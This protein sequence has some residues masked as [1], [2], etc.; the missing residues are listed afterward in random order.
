MYTKF[1]NI[2]I[3]GC[4]GF[5]GSHLTQKFL[6]EGHVV[7]GVDDLSTGKLENMKKFIE[8][9][10]F[11][12]LEKDVRE[13]FFIEVDLILNFAC[14]A[15]PKAYQVDPVRTIETNFLGIINLLQLAKFTG[16]KLVQASTSEVYG[17][18]KETPQKESYWGNVNPVG[19]RSCYDEGKRAAETLCFDY[20]RQYG[21]DARV[22]RI[23]NTY[24]PNMAI[25]DGRVVSN[26]INQAI[27]NEPIT[28]YGDGSQTRSFCF[29]TDLI[30]GLFNVS[31]L[32]KALETPIN[33][34]NPEEFSMLD[35]AN[36]IK[37]LTKSESEIIFKELP[38][39]DPLQR[40]PDVS[41]AIELI[42][43][44][45]LV[46]I[47]TGLNKTINYFQSIK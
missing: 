40:R 38:S 16:A 23:F 2:L 34:G 39:D 28:I 45:P 42:N 30:T 27:R 17:D 12:F 21:V 1:M 8:D 7:T 9:K 22:V 44:K 5:L 15:S 36:K 37:L 35:L 31:I 11:N 14:P 24:G 29:V 33:L 20:K 10:N 13:K 18:P 4:A 26:F 41:L 46:D 47:T 6:S 25:D 43:W 32:N 3:T 19:I